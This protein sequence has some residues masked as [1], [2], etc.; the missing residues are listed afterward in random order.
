MQIPID[1]DFSGYYEAFKEDC[2]ARTDGKIEGGRQRKH[3]E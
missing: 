2:C 3:Q 1:E